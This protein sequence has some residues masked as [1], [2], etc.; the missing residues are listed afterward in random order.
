M[1]TGEYEVYPDGEAM[2]AAIRKLDH[3]EASYL[4]LFTGKTFTRTMK[5]SW[6]IVPGA[7]ATSSAHRLG[8]FSGQLGFVPEDLLEGDPLEVLIEPAG[9][10]AS[11]A[12][13]FA[14]LPGV[15]NENVLLYRLPEV[16]VLQVRWGERILAEERLSIFQKGALIS[17]P[18]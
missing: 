14:P 10:T 8:M 12:V 6:F 18:L 7:G 1:L 5:R 11:P 15:N 13:H 9:T 3:L 2:A 4:T 17:N 16:T